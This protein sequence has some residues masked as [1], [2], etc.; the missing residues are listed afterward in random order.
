MEDVFF[1]RFNIQ[2]SAAAFLE[3]QFNSKEILDMSDAEIDKYLQYCR[4]EQEKAA[5]KLK[6]DFDGDI[7]KLFGKRILFIGDS[8]TQDI[9]GYR[10]IV[11]KA[12]ELDAYSVA[13]SGAT[14]TDMIRK[15]CDGVKDS[16]AE[17]VSLMVGTNDVYFIDEERSINLVSREEY[18]RNIKGILKPALKKGAKL[19]VG[20]IPPMDEKKAKEHKSPVTKFNT[21]ENIKSYN[22]LLRKELEALGVY[23][24]D[25]YSLIVGNS[26]YFEPDG[27]HISPEGHKLLAEKW[28]ETILKIA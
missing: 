6:G 2:R 25:T 10:G 11:T 5:E 8:I 26:D 7:K 13:F 15:A 14:S 27:V 19:V 16:D 28:L 22:E 12:A 20:L 4:E 9:R 18:I 21:N 17:V 23:Y 24:I 1:L 3:N